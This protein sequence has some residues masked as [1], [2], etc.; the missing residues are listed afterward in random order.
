[1]QVLYTVDTE[2]SLMMQL[3]GRTPEDNYRSAILGETSRG[4][5]GIPHQLD[6]LDAHGLKGVFFV[7]A[8]H[9]ATIGDDML[10]RIVDL[11]ATR[12]HEVQLHC[13]I[14]WLWFHDGAMRLPR[15]KQS[16]THLTLAEQTELLGIAKTALE[17]AG[18]R[19][20]AFRA[21]N[22]G[23]NDETVKALASL[24][25]EWDSSYNRT[26]AD[27]HIDVDP[28]TIRP[29]LR[30]GV[31]EVPVSWFMDR[32]G[33]ARHAQLCAASAVEFAHALNRAHAAAHPLFTIVSHSFELLNRA[34]TRP[35]PFVVRRFERL[36][37]M[38]AA[39]PAATVGFRDL[40]ARELTR[41]GPVPPIRSNLARTGLRMAEQA[42]GNFLYEREAA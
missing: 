37:E 41:H 5:F 7:E 33:S 17:R 14:E 2:L 15:E 16:L 13:H 29:V 25:I 28:A 40:D 3:R 23:A 34:R 27:S 39:A 42:I 8:L 30:D 21:G 1:M 20:T 10:K 36:C 24:G 32:P 35:H 26:S 11:I 12:G 38:L 31:V 19:P 4:A 22:Y 6:R 18:V 9:T